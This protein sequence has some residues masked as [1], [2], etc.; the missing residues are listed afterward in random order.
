MNMHRG[1]T[2]KESSYAGFAVPSVN[3]QPWAESTLRGA[4]A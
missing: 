3:D 4:T 2:T 1:I